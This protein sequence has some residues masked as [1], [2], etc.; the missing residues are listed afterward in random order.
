MVVVLVPDALLAPYLNDLR[1]LFR[2]SSKAGVF[3]SKVEVWASGL[4]KS[5]SGNNQVC[6]DYLLKYVSTKE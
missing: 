1:C 6:V 3:K 5:T 2:M 4:K